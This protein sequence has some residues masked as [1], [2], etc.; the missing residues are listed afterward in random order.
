MADAEAPKV[1]DLKEFPEFPGE[2]MSKAEFK[3]RMKALEKEKKQAEKE[4]AKAEKAAE[5][6][7]AKAAKGEEVKLDAEETLD[8]TQFYENRI[9]FVN[10]QKSA[11]GTP[12]PHKFH[13]NITIPEYVAQ[14]SS[15]EPGVQ[16]TE[17][18]AALA[19]RIMSKRASGGKLLFYD[20]KADGQK[21]QLIC[22]ARNSSLTL[23]E[24]QK[25]HMSVRR[26][27]IVGASGAPGTSKRGELSLF[28]SG[29][30]ILT[31][32]LHML[33]GHTGLKDQETRYR[34]RYLDLICTPHV[35]D[36][37]IKRS[38]IIRYVR[39]YLDNMNF[40]E[41]ETPM[42]NMIAGGATA[43]PFITHHNDLD[44]TLFMRIA[45]ELYLK[46]LVVG[47]LDRVYEIGRQF[48]NEGIDMTHNPEFTTCEFYQAYADYNDLM[49][50]TEKMISGMV[51]ELCG[52][53]QL[54]YH[55]NGKDQEPITIDF[56]P[57]FRRISML[58]GLKEAA[59][60]EIPGGATN[61]MSE[62][63]NKYLLEQC[64]KLGVVCPPPTTTA[65]LL[66]KLVGE[67]LEE[68]LTNPGFICDHPEIMSPLAKYHRSVPGLTER[69]EL[70]I[71]KHE[72]CN[73][74]TE[75]NDPQVQRER[76]ADQMKGKA[77]GDDECMDI[78]E[79]FVKSLE[80]GLPP[81]G[82]W[83]MGIDRMTMLLSDSQN[84]K[85]VLLFPAMKPDETAK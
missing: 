76:F 54:T 52:S 83:G 39:R 20:V 74:Y 71:N 69:F 62:E 41:V 46:M 82:G 47:G 13:T 22:D 55:A 80:Y 73:A 32:C 63:A 26:G 21:V 23:E 3:R 5:Q 45:P 50:M 42:M 17:V 15:L 49:D 28:P 36:V 72:V 75:L 38:N 43:K 1:D 31:P 85:E 29:F 48:R 10:D 56:T 67:F 34:Q 30:E 37:F 84:I 70:F 9:K 25:L 58:D 7:A 4:K 53:Y 44:M 12:Y 61:L 78:D 60:I 65:R 33:P 40:V 77:Q 59:G 68:Q 18:T 8:P 79:G 14:Y 35:R 81:T 2:K 11:G 19:G 64:E 57:P 51:M 24:F 66:D 27:D 16:K 6:A